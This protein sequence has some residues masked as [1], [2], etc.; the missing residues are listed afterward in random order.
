MNKK[1]STSNKKTSEELEKE[2]III[3]RKIYELSKSYMF[4]CLANLNMARAE[5]DKE[6]LIK[7]FSHSQGIF[8]KKVQDAV[9]YMEPL[10]NSGECNPHIDLDHYWKLLLLWKHELECC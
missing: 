4:I 9:E 6:A 2:A 1:K 3:R 10:I 8:S 5:D 7:K